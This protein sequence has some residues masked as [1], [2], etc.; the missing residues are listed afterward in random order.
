MGDAVS[1]VSHMNVPT[2]IGEC[3]YNS[4]YPSFPGFSL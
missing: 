3:F 1:A 4:V 2:V